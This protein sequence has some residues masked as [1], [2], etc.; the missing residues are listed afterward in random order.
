VGDRIKVDAIMTMRTA[1][2]ACLG[3]AQ[4]SAARALGTTSNRWGKAERFPDL[5]AALV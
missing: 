1:L 4:H 2:V 5:A 3:S